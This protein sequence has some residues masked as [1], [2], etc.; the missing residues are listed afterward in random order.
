MKQIDTQ[1]MKGAPISSISKKSYYLSR[2]LIWIGYYLESTGWCVKDKQK[3]PS[4]NLPDDG[5]VN[6]IEVAQ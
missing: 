6:F 4:I 5:W 1:K 3:Q 2:D